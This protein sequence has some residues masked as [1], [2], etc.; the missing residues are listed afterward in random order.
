MGPVSQTM[1]VRLGFWAQLRAFAAR[2][3]RALVLRTRPGRAPRPEYA[4]AGA[5]GTKTTTPE[6]QR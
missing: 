3:H 5:D 1:L 2:D 6:D 4:D